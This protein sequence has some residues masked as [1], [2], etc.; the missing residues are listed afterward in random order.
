MVNCENTFFPP[1]SIVGRIKDTFKSPGGRQVSPFEIE[2]ALLSE[3]QK[4]VVDAVVAGVMPGPRSKDKSGKV[5]RA[6][7][8]LSDEGK[9]L[10]I[11]AVIKKLEV[12]YQ[13]TLSDYKGLHGG[14]E[15]VDEVCMA[16]IFKQAHFI[17]Q[18][19]NLDSQVHNGQA[20][21]SSIA[22]KL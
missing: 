12:W 3:H 2:D 10:G 7:I 4:L 22:K 15:V 19:L 21:K 14:I 1:Y 8:V 16:A 6:W 5:P 13:K 11:E 9:K 20:I 17:I 18:I